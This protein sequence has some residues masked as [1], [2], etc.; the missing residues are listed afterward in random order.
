MCVYVV[1]ESYRNW[2]DGWDIIVAIHLDK[3]K[4]DSEVATLNKK[5]EEAEDYDYG[6]V[7]LIEEHEVIP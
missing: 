1:I 3:E 4:A 6:T 2:D 7:Y 5:C